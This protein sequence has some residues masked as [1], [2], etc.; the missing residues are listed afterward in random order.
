MFFGTTRAQP[1]KTS[2][3]VYYDFSRLS[4]HPN[5]IIK[6]MFNYF[7]RTKKQSDSDHVNIAYIRI[8]QSPQ[9]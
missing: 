2:L 3:P 5:E 4:R 8:A 7:D 6:A 1:D 9:L